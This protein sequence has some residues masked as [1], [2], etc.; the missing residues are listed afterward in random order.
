MTVLSRLNGWQRLWLLVSVIYFLLV[1][2]LTA[3]LLPKKS[4]YLRTRVYDT[5]NLIIKNIPELR[6]SYAYQIRDAYPELSDDD[7]VKRIHSKFKGQ[8]DFSSIEDEYNARLAKLPSAQAE[9]FG[10][11]FLFW[12]VPVALTYLLG[13]AIGWVI[14]GF[15]RNKT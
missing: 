14:K 3:L 15:R 10:I 6:G 12:I 2:S 9:A 8:V 11:G 7:V 13:W 5:I 4:D 1:V